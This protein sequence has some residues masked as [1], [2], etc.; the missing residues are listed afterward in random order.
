ML[1]IKKVYEE[2]YYNNFYIFVNQLNEKCSFNYK[3]VI[4]NLLIKIYF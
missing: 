4:I 1:M 3:I 2:N